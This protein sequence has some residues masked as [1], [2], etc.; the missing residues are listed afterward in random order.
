M[1]AIV[2]LLTIL[3]LSIL[4]T[5]IATVALTHTGLSREIARF[6][7]R[8]A[9]TGVGFTTSESENVVNHPLRRRVLLL[10][11]LFGNA[12]I[13]TAIATVVLTFINVKEAGSVAIRMALLLGGLVGLWAVAANRWVDR[14]LS[15]FIGWA[16][17]RYT[18]L[19]VKDY[20][21]LL[22][23]A[24]DYSVTELFVEEEDWLT[25]RQLSE[26]RLQDEGV[27][28][29]GITR[30]DG[31]YIGAPDGSMKVHP[32]DTLIIYGREASLIRLDQRRKGSNGDIEHLK[33]VEEQRQVIADELQ[34]DATEMDE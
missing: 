26:L 11:M 24:G 23:V 16:V 19:D 4:I 27:M 12:G 9:F 5:R 31:T 28:I 3:I 30:K 25:N 10:L 8:S 14:R 7:A 20:A 13:V 6:Q 17:K 22:H 29:L 2:T 33:A 1:I 34:E 21:S 15:K 18:K 32:N